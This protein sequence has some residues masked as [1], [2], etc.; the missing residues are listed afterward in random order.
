MNIFKNRWSSFLLAA[1][2]FLVSAA[3]SLLY[4]QQPSASDLPPGWKWIQRP[5]VEGARPEWIAIPG[6]AVGTMPTYGTPTH[7]GPYTGPINFPPRVTTPPNPTITIDPNFPPQVVTSPDPI[8][9]MP[10]D[11][12]PGSATVE[13]EVLQ[14][15]D[16][17]NAKVP[18]GAPVPGV[19]VKVDLIN[20]RE[21]KVAQ[22]LHGVTDSTG[23]YKVTFNGIMA[24]GAYYVTVLV[25]G[26]NVGDQSA[27][28]GSI[29]LLPS[30]TIGN[31]H[32]HYTVAGYF[33]K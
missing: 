5:S 22:P 3:G 16:G 33:W 4:A 27:T 17:P 12:V 23:H 24:S 18:K 8:P 10:I 30:N 19:E 25:P 9:L 14:L 21:D 29:S 6:S 13:V 28:G 15:G 26:A 20:L 32:S 2:F 1:S 7:S 31:N 11:P